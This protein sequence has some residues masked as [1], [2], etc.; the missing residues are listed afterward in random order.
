MDSIILNGVKSDTI[1]GLMIQ[2]L[3][4]I[5]KPLLRTEIEEVD[6]RD[7]DIITPLGY[8]AYDK[9]MTI[10]L[11][12]DFDVDDVIRYF[13]SEGTVS[14]SNEPSKYYRYTIIDQID[15]EKL[16]RYRTATVVFHVQPFKYSAVE[17][18]LVS[19]QSPMT[20][21]NSG[22]VKS[23]PIITI[24]GTGQVVLSL[25]G[26]AVLAMVIS[27]REITIDVEALEAY[28]ENLLLNRS[29]AGDYNNLMLDVGVST[30]S[31]TGNVSK[32]TVDRYSRWI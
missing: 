10:G 9:T 31:W 5:S 1:K 22:N 27:H 17:H 11:Y 7:G 25:N 20:I 23:K 26:S 6:G 14:F 28:T 19:S 8:S 12:K 15:L 24:R 3:P 32:V 21:I 13:A 2:K 29:V 18:P 16:I 4:P 30:L